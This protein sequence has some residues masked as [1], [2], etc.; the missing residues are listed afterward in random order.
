MRELGR[1]LAE[2]G[3]ADL[4]GVFPPE[5]VEQAVELA[6][7]DVLSRQILRR[8]LDLLGQTQVELADLAIGVR[9]LVE[10]LVEAQGKSADLVGRSDRDPAIEI[11]A[12]Y[13][14][15]GSR[16]RLQTAQHDAVDQKADEKNQ[17]NKVRDAQNE[18]PALGHLD[19]GLDGAEAPVHQQIALP[20]TLEVDKALENVDVAFG[21]LACVHDGFARQI[22]KTCDFGCLALGRDDAYRGRAGCIVLDDELQALDARMALDVAVQSDGVVALFGVRL[23]ALKVL[24]DVLCDLVG[25]GLRLSC[26]LTAHG[27]DAHP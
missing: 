24:L 13:V 19:D 1:Q 18:R 17:R 14:P 11:A 3:Q 9:E 4:R 16:E 6:Q 5:V 12:F 15:H 10:H 8:E 2:G 23:E 25:R 27:V 26:E 7:G 20:W 21:G 22:R